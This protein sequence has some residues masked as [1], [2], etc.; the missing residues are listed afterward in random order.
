MTEQGFPW[1]N[2]PMFADIDEPQVFVG[3]RE[4]LAVLYRSLVQ[5]GN[6]V[7]QGRFGVHR[8]FVV[9]GGLGVGK[10]A[11][12]LQCLRLLR[13]AP[14]EAEALATD[15]PAPEDPE[16]WLILRISGKHVMGLDGV[17]AS[18]RWTMTQADASSE[19]ESEAHAL[20]PRLA[21]YEHVHRQAESVA[22]RAMQLA[23]WHHELRTREAQLYDK[24]R[25][26]LRALADTIEQIARQSY[27]S[28]LAESASRSSE[29]ADGSPREL[30]EAH[31]LVSALNR[32]FRAASAAGLPT[33]L[34]FDDFDE[35][36]VSA[37][38]SPLRRAQT[39]SLLLGE[40]A[41]LAPTFL[42]LSLRSEYLS[43]TVL[44]QFRRIFLPPLSRAE[45]AALLAG[46]AEAQDP[47]L[48]PEVTARMQAL[49]DRFLRHFASDDLAV[50][51]FR[52][53]QLVAWL[54]NNYL[55]YQL[56]ELDE[57]RMLWR[58][59]ASKYSLETTRALRA[60]AALMPAE[61]VSLSASAS[62]LDASPY[63][64]LSPP[65]RQALVRA[66]LLRVAAAADPEDSRIVLDP[67]IGYLA[68]ALRGGASAQ[69]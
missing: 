56:G 65:D 62:P 35:L 13:A 58:Y 17:V 27:D 26:D 4:E 30:E 44:R 20:Y 39:L 32:F 38:S 41:Q 69:P 8:K 29:S 51:P 33:V 49:G 60:L 7:R 57:A 24:V 15:L 21:L 61:H 18:L 67:L 12:I 14:T 55:I 52:F 19:P 31:S 43:E 37:G 46:W 3:R 47:P 36:A 64:A 9:H 10:S 54:A 22:Q 53:L 23:P 68:A 40:F 45:A 5:A 16:R 2:I 48:P 11:L 6:T 1:I 25:T 28:G 42:L 63:Q 59:F 50:V 34:V 66:G